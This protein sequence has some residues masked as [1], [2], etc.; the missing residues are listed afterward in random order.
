MP[1][2]L[3]CAA[4]KRIT[5]CAVTRMANGAAHAPGQAGTVNRAGLASMSWQRRW[6]AGSKVRMTAGHDLLV[7]IDAA[8]PTNCVGILSNLD[9][10]ARRAL[11]PFVAL[12][13]EELDFVLRDSSKP[14][15]K[16][17]FES[18][19]VGRLALLGVATLA[20]L[21]KLRPWSFSTGERTAA[22]VLVNR[23]PAWL[24][25]WAEFELREISATGLPSER[26]FVTAR[27]PGP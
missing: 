5:T 13:V 27:F 2:E 6:R 7:A 19:S 26:S 20:E 16:E 21:K 25:D 22:V 4:V 9:E 24:A 8:D 23:R 17:C 1:K 3:G 15:R 12:K 10:K 11:Y 14:S 18:Y